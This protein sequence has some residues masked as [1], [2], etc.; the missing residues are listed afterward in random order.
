M[1]VGSFPSS[2]CWRV[3]PGRRFILA[4]VLTF[5]VANGRVEAADKLAADTAGPD[6]PQSKPAAGR[7]GARRVKNAPAKERAVN[8]ALLAARLESGEFGPAVDDAGGIDDLTRRARYLKEVA[9]AQR[10]SGEFQAAEATASRIPLREQR[11]QL[12]SESIRQ[13][14]SSGGGV[15]ADVAAMARDKNLAKEDAGLDKV[16]QRGK[17][18]A[19]PEGRW[20]W[21]AK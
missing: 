8:P 20:W 11:T 6:R 5:V 1:R 4:A 18:P 3:R 15:Q 16:A 17:S 13:Q 2:W 7:P 12:R 21:D 10:D 14:A 19:L 9:A